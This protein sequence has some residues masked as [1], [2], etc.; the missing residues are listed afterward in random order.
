LGEIFAFDFDGN[1]KIARVCWT[2]PNDAVLSNL[3]GE[4]TQVCVRKVLDEK[5]T[6][7]TAFCGANLYDALHGISPVGTPHRLY[8]H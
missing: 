6:V 3:A 2:F 5:L 7:S 1:L 8:L 4:E